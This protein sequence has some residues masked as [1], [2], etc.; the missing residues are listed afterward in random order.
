MN[1]KQAVLAAMAASNGAAHSPVQ[2]QKL[3]FLLDRNVPELVTEGPG[4]SFEPYDYGPFDRTVYSE[5]DSLSSEA[6]SEIQQVPDLRRRSYRLTPTGQVAGE[7]ILS[8][9]RPENAD[10]VKRLSSFVRGLS[11]ADL[12]A[13]VYQHYPEMAAKSVFRRQT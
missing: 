5:L 12:V 1:R 3:V 11:F 4:F 2:I 8:Q 7:Q 13:T 10:Y 9:M 6:L